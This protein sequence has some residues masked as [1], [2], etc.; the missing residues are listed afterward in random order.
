[1]NFKNLNQSPHLAKLVRF[2]YPGTFWMVQNKQSWNRTVQKKLGTKTGPGILI[3]IGTMTTPGSCIQLKT[4][5]HHVMR[6]KNLF[7]RDLFFLT[8]KSQNV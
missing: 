3:Q 8:R 6:V 5:L 4:K 2:H 1:M 7:V